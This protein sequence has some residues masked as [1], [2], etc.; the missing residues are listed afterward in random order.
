V[1][2]WIVPAVLAV[3]L[4][5]G[6]NSGRDDVERTSED[7]TPATASAAET[8][9]EPARAD[10]RAADPELIVTNVVD[11]DT[12]DL[13]D[14]RRVRVLGID[15]PEK[16]ECGFEE[17]REFARAALLD[18]KVDVASDPTQDAVDRYGRSL[19]YVAR[20]GI[21]YSHAVIAA[22]W[23]EH[24]VVGGVPVEKAETLQHAEDAAKALTLG[25]WGD[26][27]APPTP[28]SPTTTHRA[29]PPAESDGAADVQRFTPPVTAAPERDPRPTPRPEPQ[30]EPQPDREPSGRDCHSSYVPC[31]PN[32]PRDLDCKDVGHRVTVVGPDTYRLDGD[33][34]DGKGCESYPAA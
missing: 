22:G 18:E 7:E 3:A 1:R 17:A 16:G 32:S 29:Q 28:A 4:L 21:D 11:G 25:I 20:W 19:L 6:A 5:I 13:S 10:A 34:N 33:D 30:P 15:T 23:A 31:V 8:A 2:K 12:L 27:C 26:P 9:A 24:I 14:G